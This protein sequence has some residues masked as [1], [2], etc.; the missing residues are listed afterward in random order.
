[1]PFAEN[2]A[3][4]DIPNSQQESGRASYDLGFPPET[5]QPLEAGGFAPARV[6]MQGILYSLSAHTFFQQSGSMYQ[7]SNALDYNANARVLG[8]DGNVYVAVAANGISSTVRNPVNDVNHV[9][10]KPYA[11]SLAD[12]LYPV[13]SIYMTVSNANPGTL[14]GGTWQKIQGRFLLGQDSSHAAGTTGGAGTVTLTTNNMPAHTHGF[15][16]TAASNGNHSHSLQSATAASNGAHTHT[17]RAADVTANSA[18]KHTHTATTASAGAHT[19]GPGTFVITGHLA[20]SGLF[21]INEAPDQMYSNGALSFYTTTNPKGDADKTGTNSKGIEL[22]ATKDSGW[23]GSTSSNGAHTH[24]ITVAETGTHTHTVSGTTASAGAHTHT[25]SGTTNTTG[26]HTHNITGT[27]S[28]A[29]GNT[30]INIMPPYFV[31][32]IWQRTA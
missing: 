31:V 3:K 24:T 12:I 22:H 4:A 32:N 5:S 20:A 11:L 6:D 14:F 28:N 10:W 2:G 26:A 16:L 25:V 13:G 18:G 1:M 30:A 19:H 8:S 21:D 7:W 15:S 23:T 29:G 9:A 27:I 17:L